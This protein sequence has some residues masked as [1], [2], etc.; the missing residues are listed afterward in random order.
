MQAII[1]DTETASL[2]G[3]VCDIALAW[4]DN[5]FNITDDVESLIDPQRPIT[6]SASGIHHITDDMVWD[7]PTLAEF[8]EMNHHPFREGSILGGHNVGFDLRVC[9]EHVPKQFTKLDTLKLARNLW[10]DAENHQLQTLRYM[11]RIAGGDQAHRAMGDVITCINLLRFMAELHDTDL[12]G[13]IILSRAPLSLDARFPFGKHKGE[14]IKDMPRSYC[15][16]ALRNMTD[17]DP[18]L[19]EALQIRLG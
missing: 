14:R 12:E 13:L 10:P 1:F 5:N 9:S 19:R 16:W 18:D 3:G 11:H 15:D 6:P 8:M 2:E 17:L 4:I 7:K